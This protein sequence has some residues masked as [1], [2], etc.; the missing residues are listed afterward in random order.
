MA[1]IK[2]V[3]PL[4]VLAKKKPG[5]KLTIT[6]LSEEDLQNAREAL[7]IGMPISRI[8]P[9]LGIS[10]TAF[11]RLLKKSGG[12]SEELLRCKENG[13]KKHLQNIVEKSAKNWLCSAWWLDRTQ[14]NGQF[15]QQ[16]RTS[17]G[18][19]ITLNLQAVMAAQAK[20]PSE[21]GN[22]TVDV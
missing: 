12:L 13:V 2:V 14:E 19:Q 4:K 1:Q 11:D 8:P 3:K 7:E 5:R 16:T 20:R 6:K 21:T 18:S 17:S 9:L 10:R 22:K 15:S